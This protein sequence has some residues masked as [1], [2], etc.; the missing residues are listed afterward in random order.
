MNTNALAKEAHFG[1]VPVT[2]RAAEPAL[3]P[4][5]P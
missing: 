1:I 3:S 4:D 5:Y 2:V